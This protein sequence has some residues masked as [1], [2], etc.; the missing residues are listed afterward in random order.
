MAK[1]LLFRKFW[2]A[3]VYIPKVKCICSESHPMSTS[4]KHNICKINSSICAFVFLRVWRGEKNVMHQLWNKA[5]KS[6][7]K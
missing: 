3:C 2:D 4:R 1:K 7:G 6:V 5:V